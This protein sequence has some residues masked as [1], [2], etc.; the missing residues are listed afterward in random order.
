[1]RK[2]KNL[3]E[4]YLGGV[5]LKEKPNGEIQINGA[6]EV[7]ESREAAERR[8]LMSSAELITRYCDF[9]VDRE[10]EDD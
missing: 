8:L 2:K 6:W 10:N 7:F 3:F 1:M 9:V 4:D 5:V